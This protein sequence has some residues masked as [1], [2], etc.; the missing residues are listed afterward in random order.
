MET[1][2]RFKYFWVENFFW[3]PQIWLN[4]DHSQNK[5]KLEINV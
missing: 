1:M 2:E 5:Q 3:L 4:N